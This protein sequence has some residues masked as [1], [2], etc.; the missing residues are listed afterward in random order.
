VG[1]RTKKM[2]IVGCI[3]VL[4][5]LIGVVAPASGQDYAFDWVTVGDPGNRHT[6]PEEVPR[7]SSLEIG[8]VDYEFR[9]TRQP[10]RATE[11]L[12]FVQAYAPHWEGDPYDIALTGWTIGAYRDNQGQWQYE[13]IPGRENYPASLSWEM[14]ARFANWLHNGKADEKAAFESGAYDTSTFY[15]DDS[16]QHQVSHDPGARFWIPTLDE[17]TKAAYWDPDKNGGEGGYW[18]NPDGGDE[19]LIAALPQDGGETIGDALG[20]PNYFLGEWDLGQYPHVQSP[21]G[22]RDVSGSLPSWTEGIYN[23]HTGARV[24]GGSAAHD[25]FYDFY[26][27]IDGLWAASPTDLTASFRVATVVPCPGPAIGVALFFAHMIL[28]SRKGKL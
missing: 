1:Y 20:D 9:L 21:W 3:G 15:W 22:L 25:V 26:D 23:P 6:R 12:E 4:A 13:V 17:F 7:R 10:L 14:A 18:L 11:Y 28:P 2:P 27:R 24:L 16:Y 19:T 8:G 5:V